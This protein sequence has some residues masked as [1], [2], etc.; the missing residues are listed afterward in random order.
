MKIV[1]N[2]LKTQPSRKAHVMAEKIDFCLYCLQVQ[3][4]DTFPEPAPDVFETPLFDEDE[5]KDDEA[6][7]KWQ[8]ARAA[9]KARRSKEDVRE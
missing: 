4:P 3:Y 1:S 7:E 2:Y 6:F 8:A 5:R 9:R